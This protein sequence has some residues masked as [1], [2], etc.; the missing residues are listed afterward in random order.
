MEKFVGLSRIIKKEFTHE[1]EFNSNI[2]TEGYVGSSLNVAGEL[3]R[4]E[5]NSSNNVE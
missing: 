4:R 3:S 5:V 2:V 1:T